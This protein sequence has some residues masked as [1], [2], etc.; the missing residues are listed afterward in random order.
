MGLRDLF[1]S[2]RSVPELSAPRRRAL[3][4]A[5]PGFFRDMAAGILEAAAYDVARCAD[6]ASAA[7]L[8]PLH[9]PDLV[10]YFPHDATTEQ[11]ARVKTAAG[12]SR[13]LLVVPVQAPDSDLLATVEES[14]AV[15]WVDA[16]FTAE[17]LVEGARCALSSAPVDLAAREKKLS[18]LRGSAAR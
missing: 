9:Q 15:G 6:G 3:V 16:P 2:K 11:N 8:A 12:P 5:P 17:A 10:V 14:G 13:I 1:K 4:V 7:E 18:A